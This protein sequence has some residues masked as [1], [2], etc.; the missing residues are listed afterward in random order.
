[1][2]PE[3]LACTCVK[4]K[5]SMANLYVFMLLKQYTM[6]DYFGD[7]RLH[8]PISERRVVINFYF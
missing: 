8:F 5:P 7:V 1:V 6:R 4:N 3:Q 2:K